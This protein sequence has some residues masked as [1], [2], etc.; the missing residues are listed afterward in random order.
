M[1]LRCEKLGIVVDVS[2]GSDRLT[3][4]VTEMCRSMKIPAIASHS[5]SRVCLNH[6]RNLTDERAKRIAEAGGIIGISLARNHLAPEDAKT[7]DVLRHIAHY[8]ELGLGKNVCFGCDM[9]GAD[10]PDCVRDVSSMPK[11][12]DSLVASGIGK[13]TA[14]GIFYGNARRFFEK[15][16]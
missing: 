3:D 9:D 8:L 7:S 15:Y 16:M 13:E 6:S 10:L 1:V 4:E 14:D 11:I 2:H 12:Y 5:N